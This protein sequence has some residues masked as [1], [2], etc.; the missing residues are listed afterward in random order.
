MTDDSLH[1]PK[2][3]KYAIIAVILLL[4]AWSIVSYFWMAPHAFFL[5][6]EA[7]K[8]IQEQTYNADNAIENYEWFKQQEQDIIAARQNANAT[9]AQIEQ[10]HETYGDDPSKW[11]RSAEQRH[12]DLHQQLLGVQQMHNNL[13]AD[14]NARASM[15]NRAVFKDKL[16]Y[17]MEKKF[18]TNDLR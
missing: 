10:F 15:Q 6:R 1:I 4:L 3:W 9:K 11:S 16:P 5:Q 17:E 14:Y 7:A 8:D 18:W 2:R 13:V 12:A